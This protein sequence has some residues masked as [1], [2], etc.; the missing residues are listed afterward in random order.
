MRILRRRALHRHW[1]PQQARCRLLMEKKGWLSLI[2][3]ST[4]ASLTCLTWWEYRSADSSFTWDS[5]GNLW[6]QPTQLLPPLDNCFLRKETRPNGFAKNNQDWAC[7][8]QGSHWPNSVGDKRDDTL[9]IF[10][11]QSLYIVARLGKPE[12]GLAAACI[13]R[14]KLSLALCYFST[15]N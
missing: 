4:D 11:R 9:S 13:V 2:C 6:T 8:A 5:Y 3:N 1:W 15:V 12:L 7:C 14:S 10:G